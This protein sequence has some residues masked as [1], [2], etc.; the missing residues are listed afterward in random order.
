MS[1][2]RSKASSKLSGVCQAAL[3]L[4]LLVLSRTLG[5][6]ELGSPIMTNYEPELYKASSQNWAATQ[7]P[8]G[9]MYFGNSSGILEF[10][11]L[12]W[13][14]L[15]V[16]GNA[17]VRSLACA[18]DGTVYYGSLGDF[19]YL[20]AGLAGKPTV[21]SL[22]AR[23]PGAHE[24]FNEVWQALA[25]PQEVLFLT[26]S[27]LFLA[28][29]ER[30]R[31]IQARLAP[32]QA[33][34][35]D[36]AVFFTDQDRGLCTLVG[37]QV[38][39]LPFADQVATAKRTCLAPFGT[40]Q[41]LVARSEGGFL[42]CDLAPFWNGPS[43]SYDF[44]RSVPREVVKPF[45]CVFASLAKD[46]EAF[47]YKLVRLGDDTFALCTLKAGILLFDAGGKAVRRIN[48]RNGLLDDTVGNL[49]LD[50]AQDLWVT[51][52]S[53]ISHVALNSPQTCFGPRNGLRGISMDAIWH[54]GRFYVGT[55][56][57]LQVLKPY[58]P[59]R[60]SL[61]V[62]RSLK[63][64]PT[65]VWQFLETG[66]GDLLA[67]TSR[68]LVAIQ[69]EEALGQ[70][71]GLTNA[72][73]LA[74]APQFPG[75]LFVGHLEGLALFRKAGPAWI[76]VHRY[77]EFR[78]CIRSLALDARGDLWA[79]TEVKGLFRVQFQG[80]GPDR[81]AVQGFGPDQGL[82][83][84]ENAY[85]QAWRGK[86]FALTTRGVY[87]LG[88]LPPDQPHFLP[89][90]TFGKPY[91]APPV[92]VSGAVFE[93]NGTVW[94]T[95]E[96]GV[97]RNTPQ[98]DGSYLR[99]ARPCS[100]LPAPDS[101]IY[102]DSR[103]ALWLPGKNLYR[104]D[105]AR[106]RDYAQPFQTLLRRVSAKGTPLPLDTAVP[107]LPH[108]KNGLRFEFTATFFENPGTTEFQCLLEG[109]D[110]TWSEWSRDS[111]KDY[112][113]L[114]AGAYRFR[115][116]ARNLFGTEG[117]EDAFSFR[118]LPPWYRSWWARGIW[119]LLG[120]GA[121]WGLILLYTRTLRRQKVV[122]ERLVAKRTQQLREASLTDPLTGL[123]NR[124][125]L[126]EILQ[127]DILAFL[128]HK[129]HLLEAGRSN[130]RSHPAEEVVFGFFLLDID[131][132]KLVN[133]TYGH[134]G[135]D[136]VLKQFSQVLKASVRQDDA[137]L[138][139]GGEEFL[140]VLKRTHPDYLR[141]FAHRILDR[142]RNQALDLGG[143]VTIRKTCSIGYAA[144]P[145]YAEQPGLLTYEQT[146]MVADLGMY[147]AKQHGRDQ[148]VFLCPGA[149][150][151]GSPEE[152]QRM[153]TD[154]DYALEADLL[155]T[156]QE[157]TS[158]EPLKVPPDPLP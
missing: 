32:G 47:M 59:A 102:L 65:E 15:T 146:I 61:P 110:R 22:K 130:R 58:D 111:R 143:G 158:H 62:F 119:T 74:Q 153:V 125:F 127:E 81:I 97:M 70:G 129:I 69:G 55:F 41:L 12:K 118:L 99:D 112:T 80:K 94:L 21:V 105:T 11:G 5:G 66:E 42:L 29:R 123:R 149:A 68:G 63:N 98:K 37:D 90:T 17:I 121:L 88:A 56:Q 23:I 128:G 91:L 8:R 157:A 71:P 72:Y 93:D 108:T 114:P 136:L 107:A 82:P 92:P 79:G 124:R 40:H 46:R 3:L 77:P 35:Q 1:Q 20:A 76:L 10:D 84:L 133:D 67:A 134:V 38:V 131:L 155:R 18:Q 147:Y 19:G 101:R 142:V 120:S 26:R 87:A 83:N 100:G 95:T 34:L 52:N 145:F 137:I 43:R 6:Q 7:D 86:V 53:G 9:V 85:V 89:E 57:D 51:T 45:S 96:G 139:V 154:L 4:S 117:L 14:L 150:R 152:I 113:N 103:G 138:R 54:K 109:F 2:G 48:T 122:L 39:R 16:P 31:P 75:Y 36:G 44:S 104:V 33:C 141:V 144:F 30:V 13:D 27:R 148:G 64:A 115:V 132:F 24:A 60:D 73:C 156:P 135:G 25:T 28:N 140:V 50:H 49:F 116:K 126:S 106:A 151:P 78:D